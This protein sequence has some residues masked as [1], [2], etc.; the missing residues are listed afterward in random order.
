MDTQYDELDCLL[1]KLLSLRLAKD[2]HGQAGKDMFITFKVETSSILFSQVASHH[3]TSPTTFFITS[4]MYVG[5]LLKVSFCFLKI[6]LFDD[7]A[8]HDDY[9]D[10]GD[11]DEDGDGDDD[12]FIGRSVAKPY[13]SAVANRANVR[14]R[15]L[16]ESNPICDKYL[17]V[18]VN[19]YLGMFE[20][21]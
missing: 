20:M 11:G 13:W 16:A 18:F 5:E 15:S 4:S 2:N 14:G 19:L 21:F 3:K 6:G 10:G 9:E 1:R 7:D 12:G 8:S 17:F